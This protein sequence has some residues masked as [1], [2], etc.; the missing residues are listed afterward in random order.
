MRGG[1]FCAWSLAAAFF[2]LV[3]AGRL[4]WAE[5]VQPRARLTGHTRNRSVVGYCG[6]RVLLGAVL[7]LP[8]FATAKDRPSRPD[9]SFSSGLSDK[10]KGLLRSP[11]GKTT[12]RRTGSC[13]SAVWTTCSSRRR[14]RAGSWT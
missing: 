2:G 7:T 4:C 14:S 5:E 6:G 10:E 13:R 3:L 11:D 9:I 12:I 1:L 8:V